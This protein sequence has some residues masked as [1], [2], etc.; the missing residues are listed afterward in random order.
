MR[1]AI[2][3]TIALSLLGMALTLGRSDGQS[4]GRSSESN[5]ITIAIYTPTI[6]FA[7]SAARL[8]YVQGV[9]KAIG[10]NAGVRVDGLSF[11]SLRQLLDAKPDFAIVDA[12]CVAAQPS[13]RFLAAAVIDGRTN[14]AWG[15][16]SKLGTSLSSLQGKKLA[17]VQMGCNDS[18]FVDNAMLESE[19]DS[20]FFADRVGKSDLVGAVAE[21]ATYQGAQAVFAPAGAQRGLTKVFDTGVIPNPAFVQLD[22][23]LAKDLVERV[24]QAVIGYGGSSAIDGWTAGTDRPYRALRSSMG[25]RVKRGIFASPDP[26]RIDP[27]EILV[28]PS[29]L[30]DV[31]LP[32]I[33][34]N[35]EKP[36]ERQE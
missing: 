9:A 28:E 1:Y 17:Y 14:R 23:K 5:R 32:E 33:D 25:K 15:L 16:Y 36:P 20:K 8:S 29:T 2:I 31:A 26:V 34:Q 13:W 21:V 3:A 19:L 22:T 18:G 7:N 4:G 11:T 27:G 10:S 30:D 35:F 6:Q 12:Q 24:R